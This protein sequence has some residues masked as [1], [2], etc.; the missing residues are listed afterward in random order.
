MPFPDPQNSFQ[1]PWIKTSYNKSERRTAS[2]ENTSESEQKQLTTSSAERKITSGVQQGPKLEK[3]KTKL[4][5]KQNET[6][7]DF[8]PL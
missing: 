1:F 2:G 8:G 7:R 4:P 5:G 3:L 6:R